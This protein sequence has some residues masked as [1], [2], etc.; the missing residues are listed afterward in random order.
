[1]PKSIAAC[2]AVAA[3]CAAFAATAAGDD[4][5]YRALGAKEGIEALTLDF[6][7]RLKTDARIGHFFADINRKH[8]AEQLR[9]QF[10]ELSGGPCRLDSDGMKKTHEDLGIRKADFN[11]LVEVLQ[12]TMDDHHLPFATQNRLLALLAP[13]HREIVGP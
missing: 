1:M 12:Q 13:M 10:C 6:T 2:L 11:R 3:A 5:L 8:L 9:D 7:G 4:S